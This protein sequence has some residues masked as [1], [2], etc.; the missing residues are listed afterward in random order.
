MRRFLFLFFLSFP[1]FIYSQQDVTKFLGIPVDGSKLEMIEK[2]E[3]KG[4][5]R[6]QFENQEYLVGEFNG[7]NVQVFIVTNN[8]KV[9][10]IMVAD[11]SCRGETDIKIRFNKLCEQ[12]VNNGRYIPLSDN[13]N[14]SNDED[15]EYEITVN[16]KRYEAAF[17]QLSENIDTMAI[18]QKIKEDLESKYTEE[19][20]SSPTEEIKQEAAK[21]AIANL[22]LDSKDRNVWMMICNNGF[23][24]Y[25]I[26]MFYDNEKNR[27]AGED[28]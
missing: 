20:L 11:E 3:A 19:Q 14:I 17:A 25:Y 15:L 22:I 2:L 12:F 28:L 5:K 8:D 13:L 6:S 21:L 26:S 16:D 7:T 4:F 10:R 27:S 23:G 18:R 1:I 24:S 9:W